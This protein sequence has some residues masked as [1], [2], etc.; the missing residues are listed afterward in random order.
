MEAS[1]GLEN[2]LNVLRVEYVRRLSYL[3]HPNIDKGGFRFSVKVD[4]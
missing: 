3:N 2:I 4:F 1:A